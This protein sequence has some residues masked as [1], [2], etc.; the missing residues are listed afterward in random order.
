LLGFEACNYRMNV[1]RVIA[2]GPIE[3]RR[4]W[5]RLAAGGGCPGRRNALKPLCLL[6]LL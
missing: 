4:C 3:L 5:S 6:W 1:R 2:A